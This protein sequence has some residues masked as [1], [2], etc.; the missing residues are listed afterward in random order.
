MGLI[1]ASIRGEGNANRCKIGLIDA[2][3]CGEHGEW[4]Y[5]HKPSTL[6]CQPYF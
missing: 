4:G 6:N 5:N 1:E 2:L 3:L